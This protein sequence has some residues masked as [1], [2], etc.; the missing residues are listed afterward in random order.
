EEIIRAKEH[1]KGS[2][3]LALETTSSRMSYVAKSWFYNG[4]ILPVEELFEKIDRVTQDDIIRV[5][6]DCFQ[7]KYLTLTVIGDIKDP[8]IAELRL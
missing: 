8:P 3:V 1:L 4:R 2:L 7:D 6:E 5:A